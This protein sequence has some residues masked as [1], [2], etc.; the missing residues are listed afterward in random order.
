MW[1][2]NTSVSVNGSVVDAA[3]L[4]AVGINAE[5]RR[6]VVGMSVST[7]EAEVHWRTFFT[8]LVNRG[9]HGVRLIVSDDHEECLFTRRQKRRVDGLARC[10]TVLGRDKETHKVRRMAGEQRRGIHDL[11]QLQRGLAAT[12]PDFKLHRAAEQGNQ[13]VGVFPNPESCERL[14]GS[15]LMEQHE[16]WMEDKAYL[17]DREMEK[18]AFCA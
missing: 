5:G 8:S 16:E 3:V 13:V 14:V 6:E 7:G 17:T 11:L 12:H 1:T 15:L 4:Q 9:L 2:R 10:G 18:S